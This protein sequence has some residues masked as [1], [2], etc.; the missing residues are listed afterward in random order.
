MWYL[1][2]ASLNYLETNPMLT[3][4]TTF[5]FSGVNIN[6]YTHESRLNSI[7]LIMGI[8]FGR[9][10]INSEFP[11]KLLKKR[12]DYRLCLDLTTADF[13]N[14]YQRWNICSRCIRCFFKRKKIFRIIFVRNS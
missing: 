14:F 1:A 4:S 5:E 13:N 6:L 2:F 11:G 10:R 9:A 3:R 8:E 12:S 7:H